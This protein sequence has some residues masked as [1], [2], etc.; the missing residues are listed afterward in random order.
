MAQHCPDFE[1]RTPTHLPGE[2]HPRIWRNGW[3]SVAKSRKESEAYPNALSA[4]RRASAVSVYRLLQQLASVFETLTPSRRNREAFGP[5]LRHLLILACTEVEAAWRGVLFANHHAN[6]MK[7]KPRLST[8]DYVHLL[9]PMRLDS[10]QLRLALYQ[11][12]WTETVT[13]FANWNHK[14]SSESLAWYAA[15][16]A[17]KHD[18]ETSGDRANLRA[19]IDAVAAAVALLVAQFG[20]EAQEV[21]AVL[22]HN[23]GFEVV[24]KP[25]WEPAELYFAADE[26]GCR[27]VPL[28]KS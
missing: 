4:A 27:A 13:P 5:A 15:Y 6:A 11:D 10:Y 2:Y 24:G 1:P 17:T 21:R 8:Q 7:P 28:W 22:D 9:Q 12:E 25:V 23:A 18:R 16:N 14:Q 26:H 20:E 3:P 19:V